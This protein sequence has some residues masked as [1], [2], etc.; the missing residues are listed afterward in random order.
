MAETN[1][2]QSHNAGAPWRKMIEDQVARVEAA[3]AEAARLEA[4]G[5]ERAREAIEEMAGLSKATLAYMTQLSAEWRKLSL[6]ATKN[7]A[8]LWGFGA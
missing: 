8:A 7:A 1:A 5:A 6:E 2:S 3:Q 4:E